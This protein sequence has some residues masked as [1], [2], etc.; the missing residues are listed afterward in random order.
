MLH[1]TLEAKA[2]ATE[3]GE[4]TAIAAAYSVDRGNERI[5]PG[6]FAKTIANWRASGKMIPL[7]WDHS[8]DPSDII[9]VVDPASVEETDAGLLVAG[10]LDLEG[11]SVAKEAWRL[12]KSGS[13]ALS[14]G[15]MVTDGEEAKDGVYELKSVDLFEI[16]ITPAPMNPDTRFIGLK[17]VTAA[18]D[19]LEEST[20]VDDPP[21]DVPATDPAV[22]D[23][24]DEEPPGAKPPA[25]DPLKQ[26]SMNV[27]L[28]VLSDGASLRKYVE[29]EQRETVEPPSDADQF[30]R[31]A[32]LHL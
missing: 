14:F 18:E 29:P 2:T 20:R 22:E 28:E 19:K 8:G 31:F 3:L 32:E 26:A 5:I 10:R 15:Y 6:A 16:S 4:F 1:K 30:R 27:A 23:A 9:G 25:Q 11:S 24:T 12:M 7:H 21:E 13:M 17:S